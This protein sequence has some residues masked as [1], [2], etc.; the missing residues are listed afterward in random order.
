MKGRAAIRQMIGEIESIAEEEP[1]LRHL[2][3]DVREELEW[4]L[5]YA[6][7]R[8]HVKRALWNTLQALRG[9]VDLPTWKSLKAR[10]RALRW[11]LG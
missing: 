2:L 9:R 6:D 8:L 10:E 7:D 5:D 11:I 3:D 4:A 1:G